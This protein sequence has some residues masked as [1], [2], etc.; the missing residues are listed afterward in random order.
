[1]TPVATEMETEHNPP[2]SLKSE[3][4]FPETQLS[5]LGTAK[6]LAERTAPSRGQNGQRTGAAPPIFPGDPVSLVSLKHPG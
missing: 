1:M 2:G 3:A 6:A 5:R 4:R